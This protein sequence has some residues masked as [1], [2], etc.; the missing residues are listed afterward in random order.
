MEF[1]V[2]VT[3]ASTC[4]LSGI[5]PWISAE[6]VLLGTALALPPAYL[7]ALV[8]ACAVGQMV[9]K[10]GLY[11]VMRWAPDRLPERAQKVLK[12]VEGMAKRRGVLG[13]AVFSGAA[14]G[15]PPF[16]I[17]TLAAGLARLPMM[18]FVVAGLLGSVVRYGALMWSAGALGWGGAG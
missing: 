10:A 8:V 2:I 16:Y 4:A 9:G 14:A 6:V 11:G 7:P 12:K 3:A 5:F 18:L 15:I 1:T 13:G 17:V